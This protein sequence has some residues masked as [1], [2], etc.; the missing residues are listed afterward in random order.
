[1]QFNS[2]T[3]SIISDIDHI[4]DTDSTSYSIADKTRNANRWAYKA[5]VR[6]IQA[7]HRWQI[8]DSNLTTLPQLTRDLVAGQAVYELPAGFLR[9]ER[10]E[11]MDSQ[12]DY[13]RL[14]PKDQ[15]D[16]SGAYTEFEE[17]DGLPRYYDVTGNSIILMPA[18]AAADVTTIA[19]L[20]VHILREIDIFTTSDTTQESGTIPE[21]F[22]RI[23]SFGASYDYLLARG[24]YEKSDRIRNELNEMLKDLGD[25]TA[26]MNSDEH[27][28]IRPA[29]S[30]RSYM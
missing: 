24:D 13:K 27:I 5:M 2:G 19:G 10:V 29:H 17:T 1:M 26:H 30:T 16:I 12:G 9:L 4:C 18:P 6:Q 23:V 3:D 21:P 20:R 8:D 28:R 25:M 7:N 14:Y 22:Q 15:A 11:V